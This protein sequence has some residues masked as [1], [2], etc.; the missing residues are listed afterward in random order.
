MSS[1][2]N[3]EGY[4][5]VPVMVDR[6]VEWIIP[7][8]DG[9]YI[10]TTLGMGGHTLALL[11]AGAGRILA[12]DR[13]LSALEVAR[14]SIE[15]AGFEDQVLFMHARY[16]DLAWVMA[17]VGVKKAQGLVLDAGVSSL[18]LDDP[19]RGF[20]FIHDGPL[21]MRMDTSSGTKAADLV[22]RASEQE[23][24]RIIGEYGQEP[25]AG[26]IARHIVQER[27]KGWIGS[28]GHLAKIVSLAYPGKRRAQSRNHPATKAFQALRIAV[29]RELEGLESLLAEMPRLLAPGARAVIISFHSLED[30][31]VKHGFRRQA[32]GCVC[33]PDQP[34]CTCEPKPRIKVLT[35]KPLLP[36]PEEIQAN[37]RARSAKMRVAEVL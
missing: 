27:H 10:D 30:R 21:D 7:D 35:K 6:V 24:K 8:P 32:K 13:D 34:V 14:R 11:Q 19:A 26:R 18:H 4:S 16:E 3:P 1:G 5:H 25:M 9:L 28:T 31:I 20:S 2:C 17:E 12:L 23:L 15:Q 36:G 33:P 37:P 22:N 29:N